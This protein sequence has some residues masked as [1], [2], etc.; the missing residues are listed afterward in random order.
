MLAF[1]LGVMG[2]AYWGMKTYMAPCPATQI[3][4][5][6]W[7]IP[8]DLDSHFYVEGAVNGVRTVFLVDTGASLV[9]VS[10]SLAAKAGIF[11]GNVVTFQ[12]ANGNVPGRL[13]RNVM[14]SIGDNL[15]VPVTVGTGLQISSMRANALLGQ[16][17]LSK[18]DVTITKDQ[19]VLKSR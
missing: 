1:W 2:L 13:V 18:F 8:R 15:G 19:L 6:Q 14:V 16:S 3:A 12:T 5:G 7:S 9:G 4:V 10:E 11:G 17:F